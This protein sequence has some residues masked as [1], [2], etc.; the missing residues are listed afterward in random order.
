MIFTGDARAI[1]LADRSVQCV[2]TSPPYWGLRDY[3]ND[4]W[5]GG[6]PE[7]EHAYGRFTRGG[8]STKQASNV[9]SN[10]DEARSC[11]CGAVR[12][13]RGIGL[14]QSFDEWLQAMVEVFAEVRRV[15]RDDG[16]VWLNMGDS[17]ASGNRTRYDADEMLPAREH[18]SRPATPIGLKPK[19]LVG[20]PWRLAFAL[21]A[22]G[23]YLRSDVIWAKPN[24]MPESVRDRPTKSHEYV[25]LLTKSE[26]YFYD[27]EAVRERV[28]GNAH[29]RRKDGKASPKDALHNGSEAVRPRN[30]A[31]MTEAI[32]ELI[33]A[34]NLRT[35]WSISTEAYSEAHF[36]TFPTA[37]VLPCI[38]A[39]TS[40]RGACSECGTPF[41]RVLE[42][43]FYGDWNPAEGS[44]ADTTK[45]NA[46]KPERRRNW[47]RKGKA[48]TPEAASMLDSARR[49]LPGGQAEWD[50]YVA[51]R[52]LGWEAGC[53]CGADPRPCVV[54]DPF[55]GSGTTGVV[56][57][58][59]GRAFV[60][61]ELNPAY[62]A[63]A[64]ARIA[65]E[66]RPDETRPLKL[67]E[68]MTQ[69]RL[70]S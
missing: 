60:G 18:Q 19:D 56:A 2:V 63:M 28:T 8:L 31:S 10:G 22:D 35:V 16:V 49:Q 57:A 39:A 65:R 15:L 66:G 4:A 5:E 13:A 54:L 41:M 21:Q 38:K 17:Y 67:P 68:G 32:N 1:P 9:G 24:P 11:R 36:A 26:R 43:E 14:E 29:A 34:R 20:Q 25:F 55:A 61:I 58:K 47:E 59:L 27:A 37:L 62:A 46:Q 30:N 70:L 53:A 23:W 42:R 44:N 48:A 69:G 52:T 6:D 50:G 64:V 7:C 3:G 40:E 51:P 33:G 45:R 12:V